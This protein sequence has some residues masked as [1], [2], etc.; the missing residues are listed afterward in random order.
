MQE[1]A[2][3]LDYLEN[4]KQLSFNSLRLYKRD[5][6][7]FDQFWKQ[8]Y[9]NAYFQD[10]NGEQLD[11]F[12][13][14]VL[15]EGKSTAAVNRKLT[16]LKGLWSWLRE[17]G[18]VERDPF[19][20]IVRESQYRNDKASHLS[21]GQINQ[22]L[23]C[24]DHDARTKMIL[25]LM[26]ATGVRIGELT[27]LTI[28]DIDLDN[29]VITIARK[30]RFKER[31]IP[32]SNLCKHYLEQHIEERGLTD[33]N[34][35]LLTRKGDPLSER[36][37]FRLIRDAAKRAELNVHVSPSII[38]NSFVKHLLDNGAHEVLVK[39]LSGQKTFR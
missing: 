22:L 13:I 11:K 21:L 30:G 25:E 5:L 24:P 37:V 38:R 16:A 18:Q 8:N 7:D 34:K 9:A 4:K 1:I 10:L 31:V 27:Q 3:Y 12:R 32:F 20:Q 14:W 29:Q 23:D 36:E 6:L 26:Y 39:D 17:S 2:E 15:N 33:D 28:S 19:T 35:L